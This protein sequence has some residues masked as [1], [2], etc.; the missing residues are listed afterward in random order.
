[1]KPIETPGFS[2]PPPVELALRD[3]WSYYN[4]VPQPNDPKW[5]AV[6]EMVKLLIKEKIFTRKQLREPLNWTHIIHFA[7]NV[8]FVQLDQVGS[9]QTK[10]SG[11][12]AA[13]TSTGALH[14]LTTGPPIPPKTSS[15]T[16]SSTDNSSGP[17]TRIGVSPLSAN[18]ST[19]NI[20][21]SQ[22]QALSSSKK[23]SEVLT[24]TMEQ[25]F[26]QQLPNLDHRNLCEIFSKFMLLIRE[27][28]EQRQ[29]EDRQ[30]TRILQNPKIWKK[31]FGLARKLD[32]K[33]EA[34]TLI[35]AVIPKENAEEIKAEPVRKR[36]CDDSAAQELKKKNRISNS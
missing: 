25:Q 6:D 20:L 14:G 29:D 19:S 24:T 10:K 8:I 35:E 11:T 31:L 36:H 26:I 34:T 30:E 16:M 1:M 3:I 32:A 13:A 5:R 15:F 21:P 4:V 28:I 12:P 23:I 17:S 9:E 2:V 22:Q 7:K 18:R 33:S 27:K